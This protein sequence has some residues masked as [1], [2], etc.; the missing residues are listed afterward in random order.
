MIPWYDR[1]MTRQLAAPA[2]EDVAPAVTVLTREMAPGEARRFRAEV[3][4]ILEQV[5]ADRQG[6]QEAVE[7]AREE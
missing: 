2:A 6:V 7:A 4:G 1:R 3:A 5:Y